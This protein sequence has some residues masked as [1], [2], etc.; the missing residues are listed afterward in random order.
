MQK[1][2]DIKVKYWFIPKDEKYFFVLRDFGF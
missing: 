1:I 2:F